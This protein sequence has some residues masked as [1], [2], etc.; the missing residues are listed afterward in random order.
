MQCEVSFEISLNLEWTYDVIEF[1]LCSMWN[2][3]SYDL[4]I[5]LLPLLSDLGCRTIL[6][7]CGL[8]CI[9][10][11]YSIAGTA[12]N[13]RTLEAALE[14]FDITHQVNSNVINLKILIRFYREIFVRAFIFTSN[15]NHDFIVMWCVNYN[16]L[17]PRSSSICAYWWENHVTVVSELLFPS[18]M[19]K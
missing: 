15:T 16:I 6:I 2:I 18:G 4:P 10:K 13:F 3:P 7:I 8:K 1:R 11:P 19:K 12:G 5:S 17:L 14:T 9:S